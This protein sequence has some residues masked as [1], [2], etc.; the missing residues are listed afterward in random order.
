M[1][2][3]FIN[4]V[5]GVKNLQYGTY[6]VDGSK[7]VLAN[8]VKFFMGGGVRL[9][10]I[11]TLANA[12]NFFMGGGIRVDGYEDGN[13]IDFQIHSITCHSDS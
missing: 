11:S 8:G 3:Q 5:G 12:F 13:E 4:G 6:I 7:G 10:G 9:D 1:L 2:S